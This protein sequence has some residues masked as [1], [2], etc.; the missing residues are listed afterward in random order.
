MLWREQTHPVNPQTGQPKENAPRTLRENEPVFAATDGKGNIVAIGASRLLH[1][2]YPKKMSAAFPQHDSDKNAKK[3]DMA[4]AVFGQLKGKND[5]ET[6]RSR[7]FFEDALYEGQGNPFERKDNRP[8]TVKVA[9]LSPKPTAFQAYLKQPQNVY[10]HWGISAKIRGRKRYWQQTPEE[11]WKRI[12]EALGDGQEGVATPMRPVNEGTRFVGRIR[13][14]NLSDIELGA[15]HFALLPGE[16]IKGEDTLAHQCGMG[17]AFGMGS[18]G[19]K[20]ERAVLFDMAARYISP[21]PKEGLVP[22]ADRVL[23]DARTAFLEAV[24]PKGVWKTDEMKA[25]RVL[26]TRPKDDET[27]RESQ[28]SSIGIEKPEVDIWKHRHKLPEALK[29]HEQFRPTP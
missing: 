5:R 4:E 10:K 11:T 9:L 2:P 16:E 24:Y 18:L 15:L 28:T 13:F 25:L 6:V 7:V 8:D 3:F 14:E 29:V 22:N 26:M 1:L 21:D 19:V 12:T 27:Q 17:K 23:K 20:I